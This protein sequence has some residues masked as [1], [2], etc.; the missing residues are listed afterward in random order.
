V[1]KTQAVITDVNFIRS[2]NPHHSIAISNARKT[3][4]SDPR[5]RKLADEIIESQVREI[6]EMKQLIQDIEQT[7][8]RVTTPLPARSTVMTREMERQ[9]REAVQ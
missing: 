5:V 3:S 2:L 9:I 8:E 6:E 7:G 1:N 4:I